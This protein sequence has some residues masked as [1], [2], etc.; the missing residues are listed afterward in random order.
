[1]NQIAGSL[2]KIVPATG[3]FVL[4]AAC[5]SIPYRTPPAQPASLPSSTSGTLFEA[6]EA[7]SMLAGLDPDYYAGAAPYVTVILAKHLIAAKLNVISGADD[8]IET[9]TDAADQFLADHPVGSR[10]R[11]AAA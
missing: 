4:L 7:L 10:P 2:G 8:G 9:T 11:G 1:M 5:G 3:L 6:A